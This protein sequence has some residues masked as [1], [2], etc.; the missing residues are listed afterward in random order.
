[1]YLI[2]DL[3]AR[4]DFPPK[5][6]KTDVKATMTAV[7]P[8][9]RFGT[10]KLEENLIVDFRE[11]PDGDGAWINGGFFV[12]EPSVIDEI[13]GDNVVWER[14]PLENLAQQRQLNSFPHTGFWRCMDTVRDKIILNDFWDSNQA[15]WK[16]W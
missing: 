5:I 11:K 15:P 2:A 8:P 14:E 13:S 10:L 7:K 3:Y 16:V 6:K 9:G 4:K 1:M 12:L